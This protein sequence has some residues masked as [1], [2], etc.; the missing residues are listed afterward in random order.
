[1]TSATARPETRT[2]PA[3]TASIV[4]SVPGLPWY[5]AVV[6]AV[7]LTLVGSIIAGTQWG[8]SGPPAMLWVGF[9]LGVVLAVLAV[10]RRAVFTAMVQPPL[11]GAIVLA[12][13]TYL[14]DAALGAA[15]N[16]VKAFPMLAIGTGVCVV[17][18]LVRILTAPLRDTAAPSRT[19][20][21]RDD[22]A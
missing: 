4:P 16:V 17:L 6:V 8:D 13:H 21:S 12:L 7:V 22:L 5:G 1:M 11:V 15:V 10:R 20:D 18:G 9:L 3:A 14:A 2:D 19:A